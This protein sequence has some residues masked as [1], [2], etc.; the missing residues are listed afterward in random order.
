MLSSVSFSVLAGLK[1]EMI[2]GFSGQKSIF[3]L[4]FFFVHFS[5]L[6]QVVIF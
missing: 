4:L 3:V 5:L 1:K 6:S 2:T